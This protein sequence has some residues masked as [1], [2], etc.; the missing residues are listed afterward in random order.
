MTKKKLK[1]FAIKPLEGELKEITL[2]DAYHFSVGSILGDAGIPKKESYLE[3]EQKSPTYTKWKW[4]KCLEYKLC[5]LRPKSKFKGKTWS[6]SGSK[7]VVS[8]PLKVKI[9][10]PKKDSKLAVYTSFYLATRALYSEGWKELFYLEKGGNQRATF[11]KR[12]PPNISDY[13]WGDLALAIWFLDD[14]WYDWKK[15]TVRFSAEE[16][17]RNECEILK[18]CL[19]IN[20]NL[21]VRIYPLTGN[22]HHFYLEN[23]SYPEFC[24]RVIPY[25]K[26]DFEKNYPRYSVSQAMKNKVIIESTVQV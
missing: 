4:E 18:E 17:P 8:Y 6:F 11:R 22:P 5:Y 23:S 15:K 12:I 25:I 19:K 9:R 13:F 10:K 24:R 21:E 16:W 7:C 2:D 3:M 20:F 14:G 26:N 1:I